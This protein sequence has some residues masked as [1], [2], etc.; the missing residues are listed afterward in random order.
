[1]KCHGCGETVREASNVC[2]SC[3][4][5]L[6]ITY[7]PGRNREQKDAQVEETL[8]DLP[9]EVIRVI[10]ED[11]GMPQSVPR[12]EEDEEDGEEASPKSYAL[13]FFFC[14][15]LGMFG[16]HRFYAG[17]PTSGFVYLLTFGLMGFGWLWDMIQILSE[18]FTDSRGLCIRRR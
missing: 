16:A 6:N 8:P 14:G 7:L 17:K 9:D 13:T 4:A 10:R 15:F 11:R 5:E 1:M 3:G 12:E 2:P 18:T